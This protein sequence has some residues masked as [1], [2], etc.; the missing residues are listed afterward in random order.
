MNLFLFR[1]SLGPLACESEDT[2]ASAITFHLPEGALD[3]NLDKGQEKVNVAWDVYLEFKSAI[4]DMTGVLFHAYSPTDELLIELLNGTTIKA[5]LNGLELSASIPS[6]SLQWHSLNVA[7]TLQNF[8]LFVDKN[9]SLDELALQGYRPLAFEKAFLGA[10]KDFSQGYQGCLRSLWI[11]GEHI[12]LHHEMQ[13]KYPKGILGV[14]LGCIGACDM[15]PCENGGKC[16]EMYRD[17]LCDC[18]LSAFDGPFCRGD[19]SYRYIQKYDFVPLLFIYFHF[20]GSM[21]VIL[22]QL[23]Y[24]IHLN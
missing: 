10:Q 1:F 13:T 15:N 18:S 6:G 3:L 2:S 20:L 9:N 8:A 12:N 4:E 7:W 17:F 23:M 21:E 19:V 11:N 14:K 16:I 24:R 5:S 22:L